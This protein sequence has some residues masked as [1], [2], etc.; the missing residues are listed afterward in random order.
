MLGIIYVV[1]WMPFIR[2]L[3]NR[4]VPETDRF[5]A[6]AHVD[7]RLLKQLRYIKTDKKSSFVHFSK[8]KP[9]GI[10]RVCAIGDSFTYG[11][12][13]A[14]DDD[15]PTILQDLFERRG[16]T[17]IQVLNFGTSGYGFHQAHLIW[18]SL[19][20]RFDC[21]YVLLGPACFQPRRDTRFNHSELRYPYSLHARYILEDEGLRL[22]TVDGS[23]RTERFSLYFSF[24]PRWKYLRYDRNPPAILQSMLPEDR[25][26]SNP[27]YYYSGSEWEE[28]LKTYGFL[29]RDLA[30]RAPNIVLV[31]SA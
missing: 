6:V 13:V 30:E 31:V 7:A 8:Q 27:F 2:E 3:R 24:F 18:D 15:F 21:D 22:V 19:G 4:G 14:K 23:T 12:E 28:A 20:S 5:E 16:Y 11:A 29:L 9:T 25:T 10:R 1:F 17:H 26:L